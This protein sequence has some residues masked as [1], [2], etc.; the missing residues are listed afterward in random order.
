MLYKHALYAVSLE[1]INKLF[2]IVVGKK[3]PAISDRSNMPYTMAVI[4]E[5]FRTD[6]LRRSLEHTCDKD[7]VIQGHKIPKGS[8]TYV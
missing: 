4:S 5:I 2:C 3:T 7:S 6:L 1:P 8:F